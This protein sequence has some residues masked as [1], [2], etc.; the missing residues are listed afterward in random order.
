MKSNKLSIIRDFKRDF[1]VKISI[2]QLSRLP[3][4]VDKFVEKI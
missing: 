2:A 4:N 1:A 3:E